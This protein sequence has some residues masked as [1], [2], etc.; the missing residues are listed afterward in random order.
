[1]VPSGRAILASQS[2]AFCRAAFESAESAASCSAHS[3]SGVRAVP[4]LNVAYTSDR[5][6]P[7][8]D[9]CLSRKATP[10]A[11]PSATGFAGGAAGG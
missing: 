3:T 7:S 5:H 2:L 8:S 9:C 4:S 1:M 11:W 6:A 10:R